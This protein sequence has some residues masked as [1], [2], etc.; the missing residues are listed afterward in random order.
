[1]SFKLS[2]V[3]SSKSSEPDEDLWAVQ[4]SAHIPIA[5]GRE[6]FYRYLFAKDNNQTLSVPQKLVMDVTLQSLQKKETRK[7][8]VPRLPFV[9][10]RLLKSLRDS[11]SSA[12]DYVEI[13][14][15][16]PVMASAVLKLANSTY[17]NPIGRRIHEIEQAVVKLGIDGLR[18]VLSAA[19]MQPIIQRDSAYFSQSGQ[20]IWQHSLCCAVA[21]ELIAE[22]RRVEKFKVYI[23]GLIHDIGKITLFSELSKQFKLNDEKVNPGY[24]AF[25]P[26]LKKLS[27]GL[28]YWIARDWEMPKDVCDALLEQTKIKEG[29]EV[30]IFG[31]I[32][33]QANLVTEVYA[34]IYPKKPKKAR[35]ILE[36]LDLPLDLFESLEQLSKEL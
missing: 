17:F 23:L 16:D 10:P 32:L 25:V 7:K 20:R 26:P 6:A 21:C 18:S 13:I 27:A 11:D 31:H 19:V 28:S 30:S 36:E 5:V 1:M 22:H 2:N 4:D 9:I 3:F 29:A 35:A 33:Y 34:S 8:S 24:H 14:D 15:K 12:K